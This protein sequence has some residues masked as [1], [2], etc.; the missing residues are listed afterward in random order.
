[1]FG[2][3]WSYLRWGWWCHT[4]FVRCDGWPGLLVFLQWTALAIAPL[5]VLWWCDTIHPNSVNRR[6]QLLALSEWRRKADSV[7]QKRLKCRNWDSHICFI[8]FTPNWSNVDILSWSA[9]IFD[10]PQSVDCNCLKIT[11]FWKKW[12][13]WWR[14]ILNCLGVNIWTL[15]WWCRT[16]SF[17]W[18]IKVWIYCGSLFSEE[19]PLVVK[20]WFYCGSGVF[21][22]FFTLPSVWFFWFALLKYWDVSGRLHLEKVPVG[23]VLTGTLWR[24]L[25][26]L[27]KLCAVSGLH[28]VMETWGGL[29]ATGSPLDGGWAAF[30]L[31]HVLF[32]FTWI[33]FEISTFILVLE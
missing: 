13:I 32:Y 6:H 15:T 19:E 31:H 24:N 11:R 21:L 30:I 22:V 2:W 18:G 20:V 10:V 29:W 7:L 17:K 16:C 12:T 25:L 23:S 8:F 28:V 4:V 33:L 9:A 27:P 26:D 3:E 14:Q 1:M 5:C